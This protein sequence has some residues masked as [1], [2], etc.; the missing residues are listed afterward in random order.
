MNALATIAAASPPA[1]FEHW[2]AEGVQLLRDRDQA[3]WK[4]TDWLASGREMFGNQAEFDF[5]GDQLGIA[6]NRLKDIERAARLFPPHLRDAMLT[7]DHHVEVA[8]QGLP[9]SDALDVLKQAHTEGL[10]DHE[11]RTRAKERKGLIEARL[12]MEDDDPAHR[13]LTTIQHAWNRAPRSVRLEFLD[14]ANEADGG[15]IDA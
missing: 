11:T 12:P 9:I 4:L 13:Q 5:L 14:L 8:K 7:F 3:E 15:L 10:D 2:I 6:P 1:V